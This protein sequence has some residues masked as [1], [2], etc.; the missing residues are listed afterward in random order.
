MPR[1]VARGVPLSPGE[2]SANSSHELR[3]VHAR[4]ARGAPLASGK[5][6]SSQKAQK[7]CELAVAG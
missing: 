2:L 1:F 3:L 7:T 4:N 6:S 5:L